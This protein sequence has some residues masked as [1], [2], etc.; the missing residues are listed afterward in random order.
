MTAA[1]VAEGKSK[2]VKGFE[3]TAE[4]TWIVPRLKGG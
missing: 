3:P 2:A 4:E 1:P